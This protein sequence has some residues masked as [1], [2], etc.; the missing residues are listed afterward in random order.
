MN[1]TSACLPW[2]SFRSAVTSAALESARARSTSFCPSSQA[3][4]G[5]VPRIASLPPVNAVVVR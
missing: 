3:E 5:C 4:N 2:V 1:T